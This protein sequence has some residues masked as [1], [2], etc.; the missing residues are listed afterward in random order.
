MVK[1]INILLSEEEHRGLVA[2]KG[3]NTWKYSLL[4]GCEFLQQ[5]EE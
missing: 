5:E 1:V 3:S 4:K 2:M